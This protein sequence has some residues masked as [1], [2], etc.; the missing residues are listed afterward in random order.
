MLQRH[1]GIALVVA[2]FLVLGLAWPLSAE[3]VTVSGRVLGPDDQ[4]VA[5]C[6]V[7][8]T[9][10]ERL[11]GHKLTQTTSDE[12]GDFTIVVSTSSPEKRLTIV[13]VKDGFGLDWGRVDGSG[14]LTL[15]LLAES[16]NCRGVV[17]DELGHPLA[18]AQVWVRSVWHEISASG[19]SRSLHLYEAKLLSDSTDESGDFEIN[20][21]P[22]NGKLRLVAVATGRAKVFS[23]WEH[24]SDQPIR[25][26]L[27]PEATISGR[28]TH[29]GAP[30]AG[31]H[32]HCGAQR[33]DFGYGRVTSTADGT[34]KLEHLP[35]AVYNVLV[36][37]PEGLTAKAIEGIEVHSGQHFTDADLILTPGGVVEGKVIDKESGEL[38]PDEPVAAYGMARPTSTSACQSTK[39]DETGTYRLRLP[40]GR[41]KVYHQG[42]RPSEPEEY[43]VDVVEGEVHSGRDFVVPPVPKLRGRVL[44]PDGQLA[45]GVDVGSPHEFMEAGELGHKTDAEGKFELT[46][47][48]LRPTRGP[49]VIVAEDKHR[50]LAGMALIEN[51]DRSAEIQLAQAA[52]V[53]ANVVDK[54]GKPLPDY[55]VS[56]VVYHR[57]H[58]AGRRLTLKSTAQGQLRI[59]P[60]PPNAE[61]RVTLSY[62]TS[63]IA[64]DNAW[65]EQGAMT[66]VPGEE[67]ELPPL[68]LLPGG[69]TQRGWVGDPKGQPVQGA[70]VR[71]SDL[72]R[73]V[74]TNAEGYFELTGLRAS[75]MVDLL[76][77]HP[78]EPLFAVEQ[79]DPN[80][81][82][83]PGMILQPGATIQGQIVDE[84]GKPLPGASVQL[85]A[86]WISRTPTATYDRMFGV[87][88]RPRTTT[89]REGRWQ[90]ESV[91]TGLDY[92]VMVSPP[93]RGGG[94]SLT[95]CRPESGETLDLGTMVLKKR[96]G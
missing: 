56:I 25:L 20:N 61:L 52:Y 40:A 17:V 68:H 76:V 73:P 6:V 66:L 57:E 89:D 33:P 70:I 85:V 3:E 18:G 4:P 13:A 31:V 14:E 43:W 19:A 81:G 50:D 35:A 26:V 84:S 12:S 93:Q 62:E 1:A 21:L 2:C 83:E 49:W 54:G 63:R 9:W 71:A 86:V 10:Y 80:W 41:N 34:Y 69:R 58:G 88:D 24:V 44:L 11:E 94:R 77:K 95:R 45:A 64:V 42:G 74:Y 79:V 65:W 53:V 5:E 38:L 51:T 91:A 67:R 28:I 29:E 47:P 46:A 23:E 59:G 22:V 75:G 55:A 48:M 60:L 39:T 37:P 36:D 7:A 30:V 15:N 8:A 82:F 92:S 78:T 16:A 87:D 32:I 27:L 90:I 72:Q 96:E